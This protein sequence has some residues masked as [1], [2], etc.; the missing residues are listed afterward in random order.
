MLIVARC[1]KTG[2]KRQSDHNLLIY[3][4]S[5]NAAFVTLFPDFGSRIHKSCHNRRFNQLQRARLYPDLRANANQAQRP[6]RCAA[7]EGVYPPLWPV[8][9]DLPN[10]KAA[11]G[12]GRKT[13]GG[14][15]RRPVVSG[16]AI[17]RPA[18]W[19]PADRSGNHD[20]SESRC[21]CSGC[22]AR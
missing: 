16:S 14:A 4:K 5:F 1:H 10:P 17:Q 18:G 20:T 2:L 3:K 7:R 19:S 8:C 13:A 11:A 22:R 12:L 9:Q 21:S 15:V 6:A